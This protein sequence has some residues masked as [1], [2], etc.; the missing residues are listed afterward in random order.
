VE[1]VQWHLRLWVDVLEVPAEVLALE[2]H[3][4][5]APRG[6]VPDVHGAG[7]FS[8]RRDRHENIL[9]RMQDSLKKCI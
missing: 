3:P 2:I 9:Y 1:V 8:M 4:E 6:Q 7:T 5:L